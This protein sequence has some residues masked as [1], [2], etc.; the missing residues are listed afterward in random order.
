MKYNI[1][2]QKWNKK[3]SGARNS[4]SGPPSPHR[5]HFALMC[6]LVAIMSASPPNGEHFSA[7][8]LLL[9]SLPLVICMADEHVLRPNDPHWLSFMLSIALSHSC[10]T[11]CHRLDVLK[12]VQ[13][14]YA[15][16]EPQQYLQF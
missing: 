12:N 15:F 14:V 8:L 9:R 11:K 2:L 7:N 4:D 3:Q 13:R 5:K 1:V 16:K 6:I 10:R